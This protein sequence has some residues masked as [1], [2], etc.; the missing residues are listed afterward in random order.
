MYVIN[1][2]L[3]PYFWVGVQKS[4][5]DDEELPLHEMASSV[6]LRTSSGFSMA[7]PF[8]LLVPLVLLGGFVVS[9]LLVVCLIELAWGTV[10][11]TPNWKGVSVAILL[12]V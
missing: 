4:M 7:F 2:G 11:D 10:L 9:T 1:R 8:P 5:S 3:N 6:G 12:G